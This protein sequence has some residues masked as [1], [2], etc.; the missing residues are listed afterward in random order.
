TARDPG[1][2]R[3]E[4]LDVLRL[5]HQKTLGSEQREV[6]V[7]VPGLLES[8]IESLLDQLPDGV[9]VGTD[10]HA[11][12]DGRVVRQLGTPN[13]VEIPAGEILGL[14]RDLGHLSRLLR[15]CL[16]FDLF[17]HRVECSHCVPKL[18]GPTRIASSRAL[19]CRA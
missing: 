3:C 9:A 17:R 12:L 19:Y 5:A 15:A 18:P 8:P 13:D 16:L 14:R 11:A 2:L 7:D 10:D 1:D 6:S 4:A